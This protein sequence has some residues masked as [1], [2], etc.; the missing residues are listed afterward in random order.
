MIQDNLPT[1]FG[2]VV[3]HKLVIVAMMKNTTNQSMARK[4]F[5]KGNKNISFVING[6]NLSFV[7]SS[8]SIV[9]N[10]L[11]TVE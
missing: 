3:T 4:K 7:R 9:V 10:L 11:T 8:N 6:N 1:I 5:A 2:S